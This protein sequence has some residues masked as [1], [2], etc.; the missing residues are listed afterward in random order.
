MVP[1][2]ENNEMILGALYDFIAYMTSRKESVTL[3]SSHDVVPVVDLLAEFL[4]ERNIQATDPEG[5]WCDS[6][7]PGRGIK[8]NN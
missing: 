3:S 8:S 4:H 2:I 7:L 1:L 6:C 5:A